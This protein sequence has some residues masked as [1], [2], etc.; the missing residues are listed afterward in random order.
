MSNLR[1]R[2]SKK[3]IKIHGRSDIGGNDNMTLRLYRNQ[4]LSRSYFQDEIRKNSG[5][6]RKRIKDKDWFTDAFNSVLST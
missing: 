6:T 1:F 5:M 4:L 3:R 2:Q